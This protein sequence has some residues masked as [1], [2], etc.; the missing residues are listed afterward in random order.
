MDC[1][2]LLQAYQFLAALEGTATLA[3]RTLDGI[4]A[5]DQQ[6]LRKLGLYFDRVRASTPAGFTATASARRAVIFLLR[7][8]VIFF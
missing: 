2:L 4:D 8:C 5:L 7:F 1:V 6:E 3:Q